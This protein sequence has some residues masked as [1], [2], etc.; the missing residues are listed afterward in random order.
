MSN[1]VAKP[2]PAQF[3]LA[4]FADL[5][6]TRGVIVGEEP[7]SFDSFH[8]GMIRSLMPATPYECVISENLIAIEWELL[9]HQRMRNAGLRQIT[10]EAI[11]SAVVALHQ[12]VHESVSCSKLKEA[13][14]SLFDE[15]A[16]KAEGE[17][18]AKRAVSSDRKIQVVAYAEITNLGMDPL[19]VMSGSY[20][21][22]DLEVTHHHLEIQQLE[23]RRRDVKR[24]FD[25]LQKARPLDAQAIDASIIEKPI[26]KATSDQPKKKVNFI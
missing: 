9:Q 5:L 13:Q 4:S 18:L 11:S 16:A 12:D 19:Q 3:A 24:E 7:G 2:D 14:T 21:T 22:S 17:D 23:R 25:A 8:E 20:R 1:V 10:H 26:D 6:S 15:K